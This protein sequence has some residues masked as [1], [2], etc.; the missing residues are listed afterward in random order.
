VVTVRLR[1]LSCLLLLPFVVGCGITQTPA[2]G[3]ELTIRAVNSDVGRSEFHLNCEPPGGDVP[4]PE[5]A[6]AALAK[7]PE[8]VTRPEPF[9]CA[10]GRFSWWDV[11]ISGN[12][13]DKPID[14]KFSTC[15]TEQMATLGRLGL[16]RGL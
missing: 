8:L 3:T 1:A 9:V 14:T 6:C 16:L 4:N 15:W 2:A 11:T 12:L 7:T 5:D 10:R 13:G